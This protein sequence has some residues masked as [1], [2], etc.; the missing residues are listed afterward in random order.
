MEPVVSEPSL[1]W[2]LSIEHVEEL[3]CQYEG[4]QI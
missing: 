4:R 1:Q 3:K 2:T